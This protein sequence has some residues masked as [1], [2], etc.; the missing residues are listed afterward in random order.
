[1]PEVCIPSHKLQIM[2]KSDGGNPD[3]VFWDWATSAA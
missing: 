2:L 3:V 1:M